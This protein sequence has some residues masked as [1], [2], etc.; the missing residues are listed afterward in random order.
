MNEELPG[1]ILVPSMEKHLQQVVVVVDLNVESPEPM[2]QE[3]F[4][5]SQCR[6]WISALRAQGHDLV[7]HEEYVGA[8]WLSAQRAFRFF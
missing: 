1:S 2:N 7:K 5:L 3:V 8:V 4:V 6:P